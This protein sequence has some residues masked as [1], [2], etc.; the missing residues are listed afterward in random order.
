MPSVGLDLAA[1]RVGLVLCYYP[2][3]MCG[4]GVGWVCTFGFGIFLSCS[5]APLPPQISHWVGSCR[6]LE[7]EVV[8]GKLWRCFV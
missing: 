7:W 4:G 6:P 1:L 3:T 5:A 2:S 8:S